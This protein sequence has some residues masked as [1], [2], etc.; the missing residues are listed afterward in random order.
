MPSY[1]LILDYGSQYNQL[2]ARR[3][4]EQ[5]VYCTIEPP[6]L[7]A[8]DIRAR[9]PMGIILSGG[10][11]SVYA[12]GAPSIDPGI[13]SLGIPVLGICYGMQLMAHTLGG[14]VKPGGR[15]EYGRADLTVVRPTPLLDK[16]PGT[17]VV[18]MSHGDKV[19]RLPKGFV[20]CARS[21][22]SEFG[23]AADERRRLYGVQFHPEVEHTAYGRRVLTNF[24]RRICGCKPDWTMKSFVRHQ[25]E[26]IRAAV[27]TERVICGLSG[28]V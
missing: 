7:S 8:A 20:T 22:N 16:V 13:F 21:G 5:H 2:I 24:V 25:V 11:A 12:K 19:T 6:T 10:P 14:A 9:E 26:T 17:S 1:I 27:G 3:V 15:R 18:W 28:G 23:V 4:R